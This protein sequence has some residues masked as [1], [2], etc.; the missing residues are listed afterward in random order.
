MEEDSSE[1]ELGFSLIVETSFKAS[2]KTP[3]LPS[4][5]PHVPPSYM[6]TVTTV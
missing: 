2:E 6:S 3:L 5:A 1:K 4:F